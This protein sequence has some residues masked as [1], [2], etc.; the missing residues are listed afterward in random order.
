MY[1]RLLQSS[2]D[3]NIK[4]APTMSQCP[5]HLTGILSTL[6]ENLLPHV[7]IIV[8]GHHQF[9]AAFVLNAAPETT[10]NT[11]ENGRTLRTISEPC[12]LTEL[13]RYEL[14]KNRKD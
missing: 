1:N 8:L 11:Q 12:N 7:W 2:G 9:Q 5:Q 13:F 14:S 3:V 10:A 4:T 6:R